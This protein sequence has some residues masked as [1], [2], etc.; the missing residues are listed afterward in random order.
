MPT[1]FQ[2]PLRPD[3]L[4]RHVKVFLCQSDAAHKRLA[5]HAIKDEHLG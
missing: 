3:D 1:D 5:P 4:D 2:I